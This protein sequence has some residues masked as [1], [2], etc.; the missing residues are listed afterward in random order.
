LQVLEFLL[1]VKEGDPSVHNGYLV[2][3]NMFCCSSKLNLLTCHGCKLAKVLDSPGNNYVSVFSD[4]SWASWE[5]HEM[6]H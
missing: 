6:Y 3:L 1:C 5:T 2:I 4:I